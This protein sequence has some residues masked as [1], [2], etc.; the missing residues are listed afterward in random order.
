MSPP[1]AASA[2]SA[3]AHAP[4]ALELRGVSKRLGRTAVVRGAA[5][6]IDNGECVALIGPNG[7]GKS[8]IFD[9][10]SGRLAPDRG[11]IRLHGRA[12]AGLAPHRIHRLGL[13]RSFQLSLL[14]ERL[15]VFENLRCALLWS[16]GYRYAFWRLLGRAR[17]ANA[18]AEALLA[19]LGLQQRRD[20]PAADLSYAEQRALEIGVTVAGG[21]D[22]I[23]LDE[24]TAGMSRSETAR[25]VALVRELTQGRTLLV[26][27]HD[28][29]VV[30]ELADRIAV[31]V[32][33]EVIAFDTPAAVRADPRVQEAY[34]GTAFG[35]SPGDGGD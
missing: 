18:R 3:A 30:F 25:F 6:A 11:E 2:A 22:V 32:R 15:S 19:R 9:L 1:S 16:L 27:E 35:A 29:G 20:V 34:L 14:F 24:P 23:L 12:I 33:G 8:T 4:P 13:A 26:V 5:F 10:V 7:A 31:L 28:L 21:A 17:D